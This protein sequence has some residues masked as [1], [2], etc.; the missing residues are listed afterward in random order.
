MINITATAG[1]NASVSIAIVGIVLKKEC[2]D[3]F[4]FGYLLLYAVVAET[5]TRYLKMLLALTQV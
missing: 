5:W 3:N 2:S 1:L 4:D